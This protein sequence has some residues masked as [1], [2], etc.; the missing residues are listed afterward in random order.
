MELAEATSKLEGLE[1]ELRE[2]KERRHKTVLEKRPP[3]TS[4]LHRFTV[5][6]TTISALT[7]CE[8]CASFLFGLL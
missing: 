2:Y 3:F 1:R 4:R 8:I 6:F 5:M 7:T